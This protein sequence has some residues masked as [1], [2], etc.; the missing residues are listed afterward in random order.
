M[1]PDGSKYDVKTQTISGA[2]ER[3]VTQPNGKAHIGTDGRH[4]YTIG[5]DGSRTD[6]ATRT[7]TRELA[8]GGQE[9]THLDD[10]RKVVTNADG[11]VESAGRS[12][13]NRLEFKYNKDKELTQATRIVEGKSETVWD[14]NSRQAGTAAVARDGTLAIAKDDNSTTTYDRQLVRRDYNPGETTP[15]RVVKPNGDQRQI[16]PEGR[17][18]DTYRQHGNKVTRTIDGDQVSVRTERNHSRHQ[19]QANETTQSLPREAQRKVDEQGNLQITT[20]GK[21]YQLR[22]AAMHRVKQ[23]RQRNR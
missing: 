5:N 3:F 2:P 19:T 16:S 13:Y 1:R 15:S 14:R 12:Q 11:K 9:I 8:G 21:E 20:P 23:V 22:L 10:G 18:V 17:I 6:M 7:R 4:D